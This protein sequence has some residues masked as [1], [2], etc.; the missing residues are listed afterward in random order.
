MI[1]P[2][3]AHSFACCGACLHNKLTISS[4]YK[5]HCNR[6]CGGVKVKVPVAHE[7][8]NSNPV[9]STV[10]APLDLKT[11]LRAIGDLRLI[12]RSIYIV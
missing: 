3:F 6:V 7:V 11:T 12:S 2:L 5:F 4:F 8:E 1:V 9:I 10:L